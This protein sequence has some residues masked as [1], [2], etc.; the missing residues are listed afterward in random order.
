MEDWEIKGGKKDG[1]P[2]SSWISVSENFAVAQE[3]GV[4]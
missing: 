2:G 1:A 4:V 3:N